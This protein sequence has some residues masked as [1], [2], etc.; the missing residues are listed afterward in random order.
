MYIPCNG[1]KQSLSH[2]NKK[3]FQTGQGF[4]NPIRPGCSLGCLQLAPLILPKQHR[5]R[6]VQRHAMDSSQSSQLIAAKPVHCT[7]GECLEQVYVFD[8]VV[9]S[10][11]ALICSFFSAGIAVSIVSNFSCL[12][13]AAFYCCCF[14][15]LYI[16]SSGAC[17]YCRLLLMAVVGRCWI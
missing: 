6:E 11:F 15:N 1:P 9:V 10:L 7:K 8:W 5:N 17:G 13:T 2:Q 12:L 4:V 16:I 14:E 3:R